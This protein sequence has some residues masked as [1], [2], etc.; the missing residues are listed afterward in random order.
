MTH[1]PYEIPGGSASPYVNPSDPKER[2]I[3]NAMVN[4]MDEAVGNLTAALRSKQMY[5]NTLLLFSADNGGVMHGG[6]LGNN[7]PLRCAS[8]TLPPS[9]LICSYKSTKSLRG[10]GGRRRA[11]GRGACA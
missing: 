3:I 6:Q 4:I 10:T 1:S 7:W 11:R 9:P 5:D 8:L 2:M